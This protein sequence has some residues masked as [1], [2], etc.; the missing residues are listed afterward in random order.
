[1]IDAFPAAILGLLVLSVLSPEYLARGG[2]DYG[3]GLFGSFLWI[4]AEASLLSWL[5]T[6]PGKY[7]L[8]IRVRAPDGSLPSYGQALN[9]SARVWFFGTAMGFPLI[10]IVTMLVA[11]DRLE[12]RGRTSWDE[13]TGLVVE[14]RPI[15]AGRV[16]GIV[17]VVLLLL[18]FVV[19]GSMPA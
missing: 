19:L 14:H 2:S 8:N 15:R 9:R 3:I 13:K 4:G 16:V 12:K 11:M 10:A 7:L 18:F 5:G 1:M 6:T 17:G